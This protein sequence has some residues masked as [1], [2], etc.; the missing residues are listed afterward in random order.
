MSIKKEHGNL[1]FFGKGRFGKKLQCK[2]TVI[3]EK[4]KNI[5]IELWTYIAKSIVSINANILVNELE[6]LPEVAFTILLYHIAYELLGASPILFTIDSA[7]SLDIPKEIINISIA[8]VGLS[9]PVAT[10]SATCTIL[11]T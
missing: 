3:L 4:N 9:I 10:L 8:E 11:V 7:C 1:K 6:R 5:G 2:L